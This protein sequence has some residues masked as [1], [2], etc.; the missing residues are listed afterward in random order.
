MSLYPDIELDIN[1]IDR[2][3]ELVEDGYDLAVRIS[4]GGSTAHIGRKLA[5]AR[6][7]VCASPDDLACTEQ[8]RPWMT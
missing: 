3:V 1:L 8:S 6:S 5:T 7:F 2:V 4:P